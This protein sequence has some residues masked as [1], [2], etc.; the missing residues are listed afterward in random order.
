MICGPC[1][2]QMHE[3]C[4]WPLSCPCQHVPS[5]NVQIVETKKPQQIFH[6]TSEEPD[7]PLDMNELNRLFSAVA[8]IKR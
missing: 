8:H 3:G 4:R 1:A 5:E 7:R 6:N 2:I